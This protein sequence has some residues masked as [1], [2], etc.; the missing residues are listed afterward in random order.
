MGCDYG[1]DGVGREVVEGGEDGERAHFGI[2]LE[3]SVITC[4][5]IDN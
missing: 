1:T 5:Q 4:W 3:L 2:G